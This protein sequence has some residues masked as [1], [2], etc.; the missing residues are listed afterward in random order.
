MA[1]EC[2]VTLSNGRIFSFL[3][4]Y[5]NRNDGTIF[6]LL[7]PLK[8]EYDSCLFT[9]H[10]K[11]FSKVHR[12]PPQTALMFAEIDMCDIIKTSDGLIQGWK[13]IKEGEYTSLDTID[14]D[15]VDV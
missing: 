10:K 12:L 3:G 11:V 4:F 14:F 9:L 15:E 1:E 8:E 7:N 2:K 5:V 13:V 6:C